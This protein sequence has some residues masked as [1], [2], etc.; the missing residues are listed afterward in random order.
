MT[1]PS[2][3]PTVWKNAPDTSTPL[4]K[5]LM[6][7][8]E[9]AVKAATDRAVASIRHDATQDID[10]AARARARGNLGLGTIATHDAS[11]LGAGGV[12]SWDDLTDRPTPLMDIAALETTAFGLALLTLADAAALQGVLGEISLALAAPGSEFKVVKNGANWEWPRGT[13]ITERPTARTDLIMV[14]RSTDGTVPSF[15]LADWDEAVTV[16]A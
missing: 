9:Q 11:E 16:P 4:G 1:E 12:S 7:K 15:A 3:T 10:D 8:I 14:S 2:Y 6:N 13:V 5:T